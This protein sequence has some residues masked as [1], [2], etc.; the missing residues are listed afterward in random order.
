MTKT[1]L[2]II[3]LNLGIQTTEDEIH[4][5]TEENIQ[6]RIKTIQKEKQLIIKHIKKE[7]QDLSETAQKCFKLLLESQPN[8]ITAD[9]LLG[10]T[11]LNLSNLIQAINKYIKN[12][13]Q[14][15]ME[16][17]KSKIKGKTH[18]YLN[19]IY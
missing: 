16:L 7:Q 18:Y 14:G 8:K 5:K 12:N 2:E 17:K 6:A 15:T 13:Y 10:N 9:Q 19:T 1:K 4:P 3:N 11:N